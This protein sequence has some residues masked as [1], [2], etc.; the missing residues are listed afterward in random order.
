MDRPRVVS[1]IASSTEMVCAL[2]CG[3]RLVGRSHECDY[4]AWVS[5]LPPVTSPKFALDGTSYQI[6]QRV[7]AILEQGV[8]VYRVDAE[9]LA[10]LEPDLLITQVQCEVCAVSLKDL[11]A[12]ACAL[13]SSRPRIVSLDPN[14]LEDLWADLRKVAE[15]LGVIERGERLVGE[16]RARLRSIAFRASSTERRPRVALIEWIDPLMA[17]GNWHPE[18]IAMAGADDVFGRAGDHAPFLAWEA[19]RE[20]DPES[21]MI[22][23]CGFGLERT[24]EEM[25][26]MLARPGWGDLRAVREGRVF[27]A[28]GNALFNRPGPRV[29]ETLEALAQMLH[30][31]IF[32]PS[33]EGL[34]WVRFS[35]TVA[36]AS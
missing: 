29:V 10:A 33:L 21:I 36:S 8:S 11:E 16:L 7:K 26:G 22:A 15:A 4:P 1:L 25:P 6:D 20:A 3:D 13:M 19:L 31:E 5:G 24:R 35:A 9:A 34:G 18:L 17:A 32:A 12:A 30:P 27:L 28:D 2:G 23:P 14:R